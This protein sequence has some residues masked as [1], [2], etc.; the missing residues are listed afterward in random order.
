LLK[1]I[2]YNVKAT[3]ISPLA[4]RDDEDNLKIDQLT[5]KVYIPGS[6]VAGAFRNY[7]ENYIDKNSNENLMNCLAA[8]KQ[9]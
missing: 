8:K 9:E 5:G 2:R 1:T 4:I 3:T 7:Y 6:S